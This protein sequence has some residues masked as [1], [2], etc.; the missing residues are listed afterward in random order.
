M[1]LMSVKINQILCIVLKFDKKQLKSGKQTNLKIFFSINVGIIE[2]IFFHT[3][4]IDIS[5]KLND[6]QVFKVLRS[7]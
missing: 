3:P 6:I 4:S 7:F 5:L 1:S 2:K